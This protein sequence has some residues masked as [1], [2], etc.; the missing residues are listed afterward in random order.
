MSNRG[1]SNRQIFACILSFVVC[2]VTM[3]AFRGVAHK[4]GLIDT[5][6]G[7][8]RHGGEV[9]LLGGVGIVFGV[10]AGLLVQPV[11]WP[12]GQLRAFLAAI[13][14][15]GIAGV[16]DDLRELSPR[17]KLVFQ[18]STGAML[19]SWAGVSLVNLGNVLTFVP[20]LTGAWAVPFTLIAFVGLMNAVNMTDGLDGLVGGASAIT[21]GCLAYVAHHSPAGQ[22]YAQL[23]YLILA[24]IAAFLLF[25][26]PYVGRPLRTFLGDTGSLSLGMFIAWFAIT[27]SQQPINAAPPMLFVWFCGLFLVDFICTICG[28]LI[29][30]KSPLAPDRRHWHHL[31]LRAGFSP[32]CTLVILLSIH[33]LLCLCGLVMWGQGVSERIMAACAF[34]FLLLALLTS[35][36]A[37]VWVP[38]LR[39][40]HHRKLKRGNSP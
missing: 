4:V 19:T 23:L 14:L 3:V 17:V 2:V 35:S 8:K 10:I 6:G 13:V 7:R 24:T 28:R 29:R 9:P 16:L 26:A 39:C 15:I 18:F 22:S 38:R 33:A 30:S 34:A 20:I 32:R 11:L 12:T 21:I 37:Y 1:M 27:L 25:N 5:P 31:L 36:S 40:S